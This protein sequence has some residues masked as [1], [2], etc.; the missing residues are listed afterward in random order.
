MLAVVWFRLASHLKKGRGLTV[1]QS[2]IHGDVMDENAGEQI[3]RAKLALKRALYEN[4][5]KG[6][7]E[8]Q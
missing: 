6:F 4:R 2:I 1:A 3:Q 5:V 8:G 7:A